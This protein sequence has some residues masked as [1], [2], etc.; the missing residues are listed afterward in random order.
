MMPDCCPHQSHPH[1]H[2]DV[3]FDIW[4]LCQAGDV[5]GVRR[6]LEA[7]PELASSPG[8]ADQ[9]PPLHWAALNG[10][11]AVCG[12]LLEQGAAVNQLGGAQWSS[13]LHWA[14]CRGH[15][16][17]ASLLVRH[18]ADFRQLRDQQGYLPIHIAA[19]NGQPYTLLY[20]AALP[21]A[22]V[23]AAD[24]HGRT[25]LIWAAYRGHVEVCQVLLG[26]GAAIEAKDRSGYTALLWAVIKG[27]AQIARL[28]LQA[29]ADPAEPDGDGRSCADWQREKRWPWYDDLML[30]VGRRPLAADPSLLEAGEGRLRAARRRWQLDE[31]LQRC[32]L[33]RVLPP[34]ATL[35]C[36]YVASYSINLVVGILLV[37][38]ISGASR[39]AYLLFRPAGSFAQKDA[40]SAKDLPILNSIHH[41]LVGIG[42]VVNS[43]LFL[44]ASA[45]LPLLNLAIPFAAA[46][47][48]W[49][50]H[51]ASV[52][53]PGRI[54]KPRSEEGRRALVC[55]LADAGKLGPRSYCLTCRGAKPVRSKH[56]RIC[57]VCVARFDHHCPWTNNCIGAGNHRAFLLYLI[58]CTLGCAAYSR[59][60]YTYLGSLVGNGDSGGFQSD[61]RVIRAIYWVR[62]AYKRAPFV[63]LFGYLVTS[64]V[65][66]LVL[67]TLLQLYQVARG[68]TTNED[69]NS[70]R[71][72]YL[73][74][75]PRTSVWRNCV[76]FFAGAQDPAWYT[77][78][79]KLEQDRREELR[80]LMLRRDAAATAVV[81]HLDTAM[82]F[83][84]KASSVALPE[85]I[86][87]QSWPHNQSL[88][89]NISWGGGASILDALMMTMS[90]EDGGTTIN[91]NSNFN[92][93]HK[94]CLSTNQF[95]T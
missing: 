95:G 55:E 3:S 71:L 12:L 52:S 18:G 29:G 35:L 49:L 61:Y 41:A 82:P 46:A 92:T 13:A 94:G 1:D 78:G 85:Q 15:A 64:A 56:C 62:G 84:S 91:A 34:V 22:D 90:D 53:D 93:V 79:N 27:N 42:A 39:A 88:Q 17:V 68:R 77:A 20:L 75:Q 25:A 14:C 65:V 87:P 16:G 30:G 81:I 83:N 4:A 73:R 66:G 31:G 8:E 9:V 47:I 40:L 89:P 19:Q 59:A 44:P 24:L 58:C 45:G 54:A 51:R 21:S 70:W 48:S 26:E 74:A 67:L 11:Q 36:V 76:D 6:V 43:F 60:T 7:R 80:P 63:L 28:L 86:P 50:L 10:H 33:G 5:E 57:D 37:V 69:A 32:L 2:G 38:L 72:E 23:D